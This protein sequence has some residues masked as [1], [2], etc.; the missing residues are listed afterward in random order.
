MFK[1]TLLALALT[2]T[3][4]TAFA[5]TMVDGADVLSRQGIASE[6]NITLVGGVAGVVT[7]A[8]EYA[9]G[10]IITI[11][12]SG[13]TIDTAASTPMLT[14]SIVPDTVD[15][16]TVGL[17]SKTASSL[18]FRITELTYDGTNGDTTVGATLTLS[19]VELDTDSVV[20]ASTVSMAFSAK[21]S[22][23]F[24]LDTAVTAEAFTVADEFTSSVT[25]PLDAI[26]D[27]NADRQQFSAAGDG[28][29]DDVII[30]TPARTL[31]D[32][33]QAAYD[34]A[35]YT[36]TGDF[37]F[38]D[39][40]ADGVL[41]AGEE[42][43]GV[44]YSGGA[45]T[46]TGAF[47]T[48]MTELVITVDD[49]AGDSPE[50]ITVTFTNAGQGAS[51]PV[52]NVQNFTVDSVINYTDAGNTE[53]TTAVGN[54]ENA[55]SW[56]ING[57]QITFPYAPVGYDTIVTQFEVANSG[58]QNGE[59]SVTAFDTAGNDYSAVLPQ[60]AEAGKLTKIGFADLTTA[61]GLAT[62]TKLSLTITVAAPAADIKITGYS[63]LNNAG[64]MALPSDAYEGKINP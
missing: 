39:T 54:A 17:L 4:T 46:V 37:S 56:T 8:A 42:T 32:T 19:G 34:G 35:T 38:L 64:R 3:T 14:A 23:D 49:A 50:A 13:A 51:T 63:N 22:T 5:A 6:T 44:A 31:V 40:D 61:F 24:T 29:N 7:L 41:S 2:A 59:I 15:T 43:A 16:M 45:D 58:A 12:L 57:S 30:I 21:T 20:A 48:T 18:T 53:A 11:G 62:G 1:K 52:L 26:V 27:V 60:A 9:V 33:T 10:D 55:G 25:T 47:N 36:L 28:I